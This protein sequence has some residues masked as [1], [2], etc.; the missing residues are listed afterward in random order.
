[1]IWVDGTRISRA[2]HPDHEKALHLAASARRASI[3]NVSGASRE[4]MSLFCRWTPPGL[5]AAQGG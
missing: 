3:E 2:N 4:A 1:M 5:A